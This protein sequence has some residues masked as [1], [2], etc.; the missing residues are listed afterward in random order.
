MVSTGIK[1]DQPKR[2]NCSRDRQ[3]AEPNNVQPVPTFLEGGH[4]GPLH[5]QVHVVCEDECEG[6]GAQ[7]ARQAHEVAKEREHRSHQRVHR[8]VASSHCNSEHNIVDCKRPTLPTAE[9]CIQVLVHWACKYLQ[10][11]LELVNLGKTVNF[12]TCCCIGLCDTK[13]D[14]HVML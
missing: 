10:N 8:Q 12:M 9:S 7:G 14:L 1:H 11:K 3:Q 6:E 13:M 5:H 4:F 2:S